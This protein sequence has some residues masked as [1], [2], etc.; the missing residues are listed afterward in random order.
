MRG[1]GWE[2][3]MVRLIVVRRW[4]MVRWGVGVEGLLWVDNLGFREGEV[5]GFR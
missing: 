2:G 5:L 1:L 3:F 4:D